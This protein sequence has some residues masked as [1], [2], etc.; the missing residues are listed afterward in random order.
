MGRRLLPRRRGDWIAA[1]G[2]ETA[3]IEPGSPRENRYC[4]GFNARCRDELLNGEL[5]YGLREAQTLIE[6]WRVLHNTVRVRNSLGYR[7]PAPESAVPMYQRPTM[8]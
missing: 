1:I 6:Q 5:F 4:E 3:H 7:P 8:Q 2:A